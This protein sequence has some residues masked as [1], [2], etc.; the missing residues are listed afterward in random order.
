MNGPSQP[1][2]PASGTRPTELRLSQR[3]LPASMVAPTRMI[4]SSMT[5]TTWITTAALLNL[6]VIGV[7]QTIRPAWTASTTSVHRAVES[8]VDAWPIRGWKASWTNA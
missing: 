5:P 2:Q 4:D 3:A 7:D 1:Y 8:G 6:V